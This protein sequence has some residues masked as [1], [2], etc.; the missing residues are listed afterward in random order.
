MNNT[1]INEQANTTEQGNQNFLTQSELE[2][3]DQAYSSEPWWYDL[4]GFLILTFAYRTNLP[5]QIKLFSENMGD[6]HLEIA[7]GTGS[8]LGIILKWRKLTGAKA[9]NI[10]GF[11]YAER[12]LAG[13][14]RTFKKEKQIKLLRADAAELPLADQTFDTAAIANAIHCLPDVLG[15]LEETVR[16]LKTGGTLTGNCLL[17]P[18]GD[19][20]L[21]TISKKIN[22][23]G[24]KKGILHRTYQADD[25][26][27]LLISVGFVIEKQEI[28]GNCLNFIA[29]K[30]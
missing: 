23:W 15:S 14:R 28:T 13:A 22:T 8:L 7:I 26:I 24:V 17:E 19:G 4:R 9:I 1:I 3:I 30:K 16:V 12:M 6:Q 5:S 2:K 29:R 10:L 27:Q 18:K 11:D 21:D 25:V 20:I